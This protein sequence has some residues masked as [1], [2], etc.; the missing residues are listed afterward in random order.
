MTVAVETGTW[1]LDR[2]ATTVALKH[3]TMW[4]LVTVKGTF[5]SVSGQGEIHPDGTASGSVSLAAASLDTGNAR[6]DAHLRADV[7]FAA[8]QFPA[9][10]FEVDKAAP[11]G[12]G[13]VLVDGR[14][15]VRGTTRPQSLTATI[16]RADPDAVTLSTRFTVDRSGFGLTWNQLG[17]NRGVATVDA[18]L[19]FTRTPA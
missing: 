18:E 8:D 3:K 16:S 13:T 11:S 1:Q 14:L 17:M 10:V 9:V 4:G 6:R 12:N 5:G 15:T 19:R 2:T 7:F